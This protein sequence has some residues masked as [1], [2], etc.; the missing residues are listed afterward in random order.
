MSKFENPEFDN[1]PPAPVKPKV[2]WQNVWNKFA[3]GFGRVLGWASVWGTAATLVFLA[4]IGISSCKSGQ[5]K[6][7]EWAFACKAAGNTVVVV[8]SSPDLC[9][10]GT[11]IERPMNGWSLD[12]VACAIMG[13]IEGYV[14]NSTVC[15]V[16][17]VESKEP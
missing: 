16:G 15:Y 4:S 9:L 13:G 2:D 7:D 11:R 14:G 3:D 17:K 8:S 6:Y 10:S 5:A 12:S 1:Y